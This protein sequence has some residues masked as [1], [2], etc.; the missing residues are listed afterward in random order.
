[1]DTLLIYHEVIMSLTTHLHQ[2]RQLDIEAVA[3]D[4]ATHL[5]ALVRQSYSPDA[6]VEKEDA[7][8]QYCTSDCH[9]NGQKLQRRSTNMRISGTTYP[10]ASSCH[11]A[12]EKHIELTRNSNSPVPGPSG[13]QNSNLTA[14]TEP[15][16]NSS[17]PVPGPSGLRTDSQS[18]VRQSEQH[19]S[20]SDSLPS[21]LSYDSLDMAGHWSDTDIYISDSD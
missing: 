2:R 20:D 12:C 8:T 21:P 7:T 5:D 13:F 17:S 10:C 19:F 15:T 3:M 16:R 6:A 9:G 18:T 4:I 14:S 11:F 1:M